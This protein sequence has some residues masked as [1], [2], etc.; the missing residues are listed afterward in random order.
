MDGCM[1]VWMDR[2][3]HMDVWMDVWMDGWMYGRWDVRLNN[4]CVTE[5]VWLRRYKRQT[6][7][8]GKKT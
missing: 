6:E 2:W 3:M 4:T 1:D 8:N 5:R 7:A